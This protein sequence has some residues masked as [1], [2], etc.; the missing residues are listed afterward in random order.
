MGLFGDLF[1]NSFGIDSLV[2]S[3]F[4]EDEINPSTGM[5]MIGGIGGFDAGG[6]TYGS[7]G[8]FHTDDSFCNDIND[9]IGCADIFDT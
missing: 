8:S 6:N 9:S 1:S 3:D 2:E 4:I 5:P 7:D